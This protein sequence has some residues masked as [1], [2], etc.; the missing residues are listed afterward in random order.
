M[1]VHRFKKYVIVCSRV[2]P[3]ESNSSYIMHGFMNF[4]TG[5]SAEAIDLR[6][7]IV[8]KIIKS[9]SKLGNILICVIYL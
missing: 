4:I 8:F 5:N 3:G 1:P 2:H 7:K 9:P 6:R